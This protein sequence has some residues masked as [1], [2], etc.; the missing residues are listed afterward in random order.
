MSTCWYRR[1]AHTAHE[2]DV[3]SAIMPIRIARFEMGGD[4]DQYRRVAPRLTWSRQP[5]G[6]PT[7]LPD[8]PL[9]NRP[10]R[11]RTPCSPCF[12]RS[13]SGIA[14][15]H[16]DNPAPAQAVEVREDIVLLWQFNG[17]AAHPPRLPTD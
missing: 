17:C 16:N 6:R 12:I 3:V 5:R 13:R 9:A 8:R 10:R 14:N 7:G 2:A 1:S 11:S 15:S 4:A